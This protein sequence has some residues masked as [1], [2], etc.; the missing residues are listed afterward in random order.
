[1]TSLPVGQQSEDFSSIIGM[2]LAPIDLGA[3]QHDPTAPPQ[4]QVHPLPAAHQQ[5]PQLHIPPHF[6]ALAPPNVFSLPPPDY[7]AL[8]FA[9]HASRERQRSR[10]HRD[11]TGEGYSGIQMNLQPIGVGLLEGLDARS[12]EDF[13]R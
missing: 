10:G 2:A 8:D 4:A 11:A 6:P 3:L 12:M 1:M 5:Q 9:N 7:S 13:E